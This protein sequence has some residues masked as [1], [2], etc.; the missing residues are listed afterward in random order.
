MPCEVL[1]ADDP[2]S[3]V[4]DIFCIRMLRPYLDYIGHACACVFGLIS[5]NPATVRFQERGFSDLS[6][7]SGEAR[8]WD[9]FPRSS[10]PQYSCRATP[11]ARAKSLDASLLS[12]S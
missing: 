11:R 7:S 1:L 2:L 4:T 8:N 5:L 3:A 9:G 12:L 6:S 10:Q